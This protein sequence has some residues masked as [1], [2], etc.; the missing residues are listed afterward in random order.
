MVASQEHGRPIAS[1]NGSCSR[2][3]TTEDHQVTPGVSSTPVSAA[4][5]VDESLNLTSTIQRLIAQREAAE[6][7]LLEA[8]QRYRNLIDAMGAAVYTTDIEGRL[9]LYNEAAAALW[10]RRPTLGDDRFCGAWKL[11]EVNGSPMPHNECPM[12]LS[13]REKRP[14]IGGEAVA[15]RPDGSR[16]PFAAYPAP[17]RDASGAIVGAV[18]VLVDLTERRLT[19]AALRQSD[20]RRQEMGRLNLDLE[21][22]VRNEV[23]AREA[24][25]HQLA[26]ARRMEALGRLAGGIAHDFNNILQAVQSTLALI[27]RRAGDADSVRRHARVG[28]DVT[29]RGSSITQRLL[30]FSRQGELRTETIDLHKL[31]IELA[32]VL[33]HTLGAGIALRMETDASMPFVTADRGQLETVLVNLATNARDAMPDGG[34]LTFTASADTMEPDAVVSSHP[35]LKPGRYVRID[36]LDTG[37]GMDP[38]TLSR[39][40]EPFFTTKA[41]GKGTGL[42]MAMARGFSE[43]SGGSLHVVSKPGQGTKVM[44][45]LPVATRASAGLP[46]TAAKPVDEPPV[47]MPTRLMLVDDDAAVRETLSEQLELEGFELIV[48]DDG[49]DALDLLDGDD[50]IDLLVSDL[51]MP[52]MDGLTLIQ[53]AQRRRPGLPAIL[54]TGHAEDSAALLGGRLP[55][56]D[57]G[58]LRKPITLNNLLRCMNLLLQAKREEPGEA[59]GDRELF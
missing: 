17:L 26:Q 45:W 28:L 1:Q 2:V 58:L 16:V 55:R 31:F 27:E 18:N 56:Q 44:L 10:G 42:G 33:S 6:M 32:E 41:L 25:Q 29:E 24:V 9:T 38:A 37:A 48:A 49:P 20:D 12:A 57:F 15:E 3:V 30:I 35:G 51:S 21:T 40:S 43:Q 23:L 54:V 53:E 39:V 52:R 5:T 22:R 50:K 46:G 47:Q 13:L 34:T 36:V 14:I 19:E 7:A 4:D 59:T 11:Y 8:N